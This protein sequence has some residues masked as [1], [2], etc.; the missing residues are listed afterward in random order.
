MDVKERF[1]LIKSVGEEIITDEELKSLLEK[2]TSPVVYDGFEPSGKLHIAQ[3]ILRGISVNKMISAGC[4]VKMLV[5]DWHAWANNKF[6]GD[7]DKIQ[8]A[9]EYMIEVWKAAGMTTDKVEFVWANDLVKDSDY[10]KTVMNVS[11]ASTVKRIVRCSQIMGRK[12]NDNL[13]A[14]QILYPCMQCA[15]IFHLGVDITQLG[16]DQRKVNMLAREVGPTLG[17]WK[18][19]V[20]SHHML[21]GLGKPPKDVATEEKVM[22][23]KM[24]KS[25]PHTAIFMTDSSKEIKNKLGKAYCPEKVV[26]ENPIMEYAKYIIFEKF[27]ELNIKRPAK[28]G[29]DLSIGSYDELCKMYSSGKLHP[30]D[31]KNGVADHLDQLIEPV[32]THFEKNKKAADLLKQVESFNVTR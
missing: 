15:D 10:W 6:G 7:L 17:F 2:K 22:E 1:E 26:D 28:F 21:M 8:T 20:V 5:A 4:K 23:L 12:E 19:V 32:R 18:P 30:L 3:G 11:R 16:M 24:S 14:S 27:K 31:L 29:G 13:A 9:G 25:K